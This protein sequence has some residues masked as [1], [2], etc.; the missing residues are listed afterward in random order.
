MNTARTSYLT[1]GG[2][3]ALMI[4]LFIAVYSLNIRQYRTSIFNVE[5]AVDKSLDQQNERALA[6]MERMEAR[7]YALY[8]TDQV[9]EEDLFA[10]Q[11]GII[12][13][14]C[15]ADFITGTV[16]ETEANKAF[17][18]GIALLPS[19]DALPLFEKAAT[20]TAENEKALYQKISALFNVLE[21]RSDPSL[22]CR[23]IV[24]LEQQQPALSEPQ[25]AFFLSLLKERFANLD[26][27][28]TRLSELQNTASSIRTKIQPG[29][30]PLRAAV[31]EQI[32]AA[33]EDGLALLY[34]PDFEALGIGPLSQTPTGL[35]REILPGLYVTASNEILEEEKQ[36]ITK[37]YQAGNVILALMVLLAVLLCTG[38]ILTFKKRRKLDAA[39]TQFIATVSHELRT[40][41]S[42][43]R[44]HAETLHHK[45]IPK[46]KIA[47]YHQTILTESERLTGIVNNV[48]D[49]SRMERGKLTIHLE[50]VNLSECTGQIIESFASRFE[51]EGF[52]I[53]QRIQPDII[54]RADPLA[55]SQI[56]FNL[57]DN[58]VKYSD[59]IKIIEIGLDVSNGWNILTVADQ[60]IGIPDKLKKHI[61]EEF[62]RSDDCKV[63]ARRGSGIGLNVAQRLA[64]KMGGTIE[65]ADNHPKGSV[66]TVRLKERNETTGG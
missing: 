47:E 1:A 23:I 39:R 54:S 25:R 28:E 38:L 63:T 13:P 41:L 57:L 14:A 12:L 32:F 42:L 49:F 64:G 59:G 15:I 8:G 33:R 40:P 5:N 3:I 17:K 11:G 4:G 50:T 18:E 21:Y 34:T 62:T 58:A 2:L 24:G 26:Y 45:R 46:E 55:F 7:G 30:L 10:V 65:V 61:F 56:L 31:N 29:H 43:I 53:E 44:L 66:F 16:S 6:Y 27:I 48:L 36:R 60:G 51:T 37:Q 9:L 52:K 35:Y 20:F 19:A 22:A